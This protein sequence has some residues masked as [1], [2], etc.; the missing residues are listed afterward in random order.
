MKSLLILFMLLTA[1][2]AM[3]DAIC[4]GNPQAQF[5]RLLN[6]STSLALD[7]FKKYFKTFNYKE[8]ITR[9]GFTSYVCFQDSP[10]P[11]PDSILFFHEKRLIAFF[12]PKLISKRITATTLLRGTTVSYFGKI[13]PELRSKFESIYFSYI[14]QA[15]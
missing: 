4:K 14:E 6:S 12:G 1:P 5:E 11:W 10:T 3:A 7:D 2:V 8:F 15:N 13:T 9:E